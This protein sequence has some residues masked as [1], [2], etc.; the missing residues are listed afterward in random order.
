MSAKTDALKVA[1]DN[2]TTKVTALIA[3]ATDLQTQ[4][5]SHAADDA[6]V[7]AATDQVNALADS[8]PS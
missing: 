5:D 8:I 7:Q 3:K 6:A 4:V 1:L 2:L